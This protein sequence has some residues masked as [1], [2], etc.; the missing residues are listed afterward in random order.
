[1]LFWEEL[2]ILDLMVTTATLQHS[3]VASICW[4][5]IFN[6][7][8][9][10]FPLRNHLCLE[11]WVARLW[12]SWFA[13]WSGHWRKR[14]PSII[15]PRAGVHARL[16]IWTITSWPLLMWAIHSRFDSLHSTQSVS[17][18]GLWIC[19]THA[20][21]WRNH[22]SGS[23]STSRRLD[24][25]KYTQNVH[26]TI[27]KEEMR[28]R[29]GSVVSPLTPSSP[30]ASPIPFVSTGTSP[31]EI[32]HESSFC[33][34]SR[35]RNCKYFVNGELEVARS[36]GDFFLKKPL[37]AERKW[38]YPTLEREMKGVD[39]FVDDVVSSTPSIQF[40]FMWWLTCRQFRL[41]AEDRF[42]VIATDGLW[43]VI[44]P[45]ACISIVNQLASRYSLADVC[46]MLFWISQQRGSYDNTSIILIDLCYSP[47]VWHVCFTLWIHKLCGGR[48]NR[49]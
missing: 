38:R 28:T 21:P 48:K 27:V 24:Y 46:R 13:C 19:G 1:M 25:N 22:R 23:N 5:C 17:R 7:I 40:A 36:L 39:G 31:C 4:S 32:T 20:D 35:M 45:K 8:H 12:R 34:F 2:I 6:V 26:S 9:R 41:K 11:W 37:L 16:C 49:S 33:F 10:I 29:L 47:S 30:S 42:I 15:F 43:E 14:W 44:N 18:K 3:G